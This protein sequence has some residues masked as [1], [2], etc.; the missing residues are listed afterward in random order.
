MDELLLNKKKSSKH[1]N[2]FLQSYP[3]GGAKWIPAWE[4]HSRDPTLVMWKA[5]YSN[6]AGGNFLFYYFKKWI[7]IAEKNIGFILKISGLQR[8]NLMASLHVYPDGIETVPEEILN[9]KT[10]NFHQQTDIQND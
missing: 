1:R 6:L 9:S 5:C 7:C 2:I 8:R 4:L 10:F 3:G